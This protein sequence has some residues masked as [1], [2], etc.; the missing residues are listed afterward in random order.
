MTSE[1]HKQF[2]SLPNQYDFDKLPTEAKAIIN[3]EWEAATKCLVVGYQQLGLDMIIAIVDKDAKATPEEVEASWKAFEEKRK[4]Y[5]AYKQ[6]N[7]G[8][9][10]IIRGDVMNTDDGGWT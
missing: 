4:S 6:I 7:V 9:A 10:P 5:N 2:T 1:E 3:P 8:P